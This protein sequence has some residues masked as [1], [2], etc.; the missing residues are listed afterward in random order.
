MRSASFGYVFC[1]IDLGIK[2]IIAEKLKLK[3][4]YG[5]PENK[6]IDLQNELFLKIKSQSVIRQR[7]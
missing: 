4:Q 3:I 5:T 2:Y 7:G 6:I 1:F